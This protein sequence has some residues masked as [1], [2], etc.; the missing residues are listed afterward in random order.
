MPRVHEMIESKYLKKEDVGEDGTVVTIATIDRV[1]V[2]AKGEEPEHKWVMGFE[3]FDKPMVLNPTNLKLAEKA[4]GS[5]DTDDWMGKKIIVY[6]D[7]NI[8]FGKELV[9]GIRIKAFRK[10]G[11]PKEMP[12]GVRHQATRA[13]EDVDPDGPSF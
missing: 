2:A 13:P 3:E 12:R 10:V 8:T 11:P 4:L 6:N 9:G 7:P 1:N 5:D